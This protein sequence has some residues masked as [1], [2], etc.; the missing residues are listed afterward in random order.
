M[1]INPARVTFR[2]GE[3]FKVGLEYDMTED[4]T[5]S[6]TGN[7]GPD[8]EKLSKEPEAM[9]AAAQMM[10]T[11]MDTAKLVKVFIKM[12]DKRAELKKAFDAEDIRIKGQQEEVG[13]VLLG[14]LNDNMMDS[15]RTSSGTFFRK[16]KVVPNGSDWDAFFAWV[17][18]H[19][20]F[21]AFE[22]RIKGTFV[23]QFME[24]NAGALPPG[25]S[26]HRTFEASVRRS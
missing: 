3:K 20:A 9:N 4:D 23:K 1:N 25:V 17:K 8:W 21:D 16:E 18:E 22:R 13:N 11:N 2:F 10:G 14:F 15:V 7:Q 6:A 19:D 26:I 24:E 5:V 12:R